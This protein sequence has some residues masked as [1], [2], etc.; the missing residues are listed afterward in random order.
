MPLMPVSSWQTPSYL[1]FT[2]SL[3]Y[4]RLSHG[5]SVTL[6]PTV[7]IWGDE[8][9]PTLEL[10][11]K[12]D[13]P[14]NAIHLNPQPDFI[15]KPNYSRD[16]LHQAPNQNHYLPPIDIT[17]D[18]NPVLVLPQFFLWLPSHV[19]VHN[20]FNPLQ[21]VITRNISRISPWNNATGSLNLTLL[22]EIPF[23]PYCLW[24]GFTHSLHLF[25]IPFSTCGV[26]L[27]DS[28]KV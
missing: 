14:F 10:A 27:G 8:V 28:L 7:S 12:I 25:I 22:C 23:N 19:F 11:P 4:N 1:L 13:P 26:Q 24:T 2:S 16:C 21:Y 9:S 20:N 6:T 18:I 3:D 15:L 5:T 17:F